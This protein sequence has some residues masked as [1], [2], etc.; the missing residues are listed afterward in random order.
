M[1]NMM[2]YLTV[3][4]RQRLELAR[5]YN[6]ESFYSPFMGNIYIDSKFITEDL[7]NKVHKFLKEN[8]DWVMGYE[9]NGESMNLYITHLD[10]LMEA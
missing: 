10:D 2:D 6:L 5:K 7:M 3:L 4:G 8:Q 9:D 1:P